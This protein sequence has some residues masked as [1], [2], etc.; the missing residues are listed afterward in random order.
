MPRSG[1]TTKHLVLCLYTASLIANGTGEAGALPPGSQS[2][3]VQPSPTEL[4]L[5]A[6]SPS[7]A[8][9]G[10]LV[11]IIG[12]GFGEEIR[13]RFG[14]ASVQTITQ[15]DAYTLAVIVPEGPPGGTL[16]EVQVR[17]QKSSLNFLR[18]STDAA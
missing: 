8:P 3:R 15:L 9:A 18:T 17:G 4:S 11:K 6:V 1:P 13:V 16:I 5:T 12:I 14:G 10:A 2:V 7:A